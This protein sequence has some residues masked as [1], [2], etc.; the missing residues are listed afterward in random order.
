MKKN[1]RGWGIEIGMDLFGWK[2]FFELMP[3]AFN[4][5]L[6]AIKKSVMTGRGFHF[7]GGPFHIWSMESEGF[8]KIGLSVRPQYNYFWWDNPKVPNSGYKRVFGAQA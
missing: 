6:L 1:I 7:V 4:R 8:C 5:P 3:L 2:L